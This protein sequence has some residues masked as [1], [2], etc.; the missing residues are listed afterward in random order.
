MYTATVIGLSIL[1]L[2][3]NRAAI[4]KLNILLLFLH[5][6]LNL[7]YESNNKNYYLALSNIVTLYS[8]CELNTVIVYL[9]NCNILYR[10]KGSSL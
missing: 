8:V 6:I 3:F 5:L 2:L 1:L 10:Y 4:L 7:R 9:N